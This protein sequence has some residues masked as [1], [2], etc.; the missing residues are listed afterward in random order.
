MSAVSE[1]LE[2]N[3]VQ[4]LATVGRDGKAKVRPF[5]FM[6][7][8]DGRLWFC[9]NNQKDVYKDMQENPNIEVC[10]SDPTYAWIRVHGRAVFVNDM[11]IKE[12][13]VQ[14]PIVKAQYGTADNP[15]LEVFYIADAH[16][17]IADFSGEPPK[18][19]DLRG[20][21]GET[22]PSDRVPGRRGLHRV[23]AVLQQV[24]EEVHR[25]LDGPRG[26]GHR[27]VHR[28][29]VVRQGL[30]EGGRAR[31][32]TDLPDCPVEIALG[33]IGDKWAVIILRDLEAGPMRFGE[34]R[35]SMDI[36]QKVL[37]ERLRD[38]EHSGIVSRREVGDARGS[39]EYSLTP[40]GAS[41]SAAVSH[42]AEWGESYRE[43]DRS[44]S[45][46]G[47]SGTDR[48]R[49]PVTVPTPRGS[50]GRRGHPPQHT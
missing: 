6:T 9:T 46:D 42:L 25:H 36:S 34:L 43:W 45:S 8:R 11:S 14:N 4:Y 27:P 21:R 40:M 24:P 12:V 31:D 23:Q 7:E 1:F 17:T 19:Y 28:L 48:A 3:P 5:M 50:I 10:V 49:F 30:P 2:K 41:L 22:G 16:A 20:H 39:V 47:P 37:T 35:R 33:I 44:R 38:L 15:L 32:M 18:E 26:D 29:R 13:C